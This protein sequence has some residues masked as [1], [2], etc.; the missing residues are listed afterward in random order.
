MRL[1]ITLCM[2]GLLGLWSAPSSAQAFFH[3]GFER[4]ADAARIDAA[5]LLTQASFGP[6]LPEIERVSLLG[7]D[8]WLDEQLAMPA[9]L[10]GAFVDQIAAGG[11]DIYQNVR[12]EA[13]FRQAMNAPDQLRQR[14]AF[15]LSQIF[16]VS[17]RSP[18]EGAPRALTDYYDMLLTH[19]FGDYRELLEAVTL[20]P[21]MGVYLS[22]RGNQKPDAA[23]NI[24][25]DENYAREIMQL[26]SIGL[27]ML[28]PDGSVR[29]GDPVTA[30]A[31]P[32]PAYDQHSI[33]GFAHV[34]TGWN[35]SECADAA[36][37]RPWEWE[38]CYPQSEWLADSG[39]RVPL[40]AVEWQHATG[41]KPLLSYA[42]VDRGSVIELPD[43]GDAATDLA[44]ALDTLAQHPNV[45]PFISRQLIQR[46]VTSNPTPAYVERIAAV[47]DDDGSGSYGNLGAVVRAILLDPEARSLARADD[48]DFGKLR[49]PL[50]RRTHVLRALRATSPAGRFYEWEPER[51]FGQAP[52]RSPSVFNFYRPDYT[53]PGEI[54]QSGLQSPEFQITTDTLIVAT[55]NALAADIYWHFSGNEYLDDDVLQLDLANEEAFA[56]DPATLVD[57]YDLLFMNG[58][59]PDGM[60]TV[61]VEHVGSIGAEYNPNWRRDRVQ[62]ALVLI[63]TSAQYAVQR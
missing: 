20:H 39:W 15:A 44:D 14:V 42:G 29:D 10:H 46:L 61:L 4:D 34:F 33:R 49:E 31:Q 58:L 24:R 22:M 45:A 17:D 32:V 2:C 41:A 6:T 26:F 5:R 18:L 16:V 48:D 8:G 54:A 19:A 50:L 47:F 25:P 60:R 62:D 7:A 43:G 56:D 53:L 35:W 23:A 3:D 9:S 55:T 37:S 13:W 38:Y 36:E 12:L 51:A 21:A 40:R 27:V 30:G 63:I 11:E 52:L 59:M 57:R 28:E 1:A